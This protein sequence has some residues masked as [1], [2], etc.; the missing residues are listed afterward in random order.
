MDA[1]DALGQVQND[2]NSVLTTVI[3]RKFEPELRQRFEEERKDASVFPTV[4]EIVDFLEDLARQL[5]DSMLGLG[6]ETRKSSKPPNN[7][8]QRPPKAALH[9]SKSPNFKCSLCKSNNHSIYKCY[10]FSDLSAEKRREFIKSAG[11]CFNCLGTSHSVAQCGS[12]VT[13]HTC[14]DRHHTLLHRPSSNDK[15]G[16]STLTT[17]SSG[18]PK[19]AHTCASQHNTTQIVLLGTA[20]VLCRDSSGELQTVRVMIDNGS[21]ISAI[22][23]KCARR[24]GLKIQPF[25]QR[26]SGLSNSSVPNPIGR[27]DCTLI[28]RTQPSSQ[29][30]ASALV[31][32]SI[33]GPQPPLNV[34]ASVIAQVNSL[35]LADP[36]FHKTCEI[37][38]LLGADLYG[39]VMLGEKLQNQSNPHC[40]SSI[41]GWVLIGNAPASDSRYCHL[42]FF[43]F[44][45]TLRPLD[46]ALCKF[47]EIESISQKR[48]PDPAE[49]ACENLFA[50]QHSRTPQGRY[51][52]PLPFSGDPK[53]LGSNRAQALK[54]YLSLERRLK[55]DPPLYEAYQN[56]FS[57]YLSLG[58]M[59]L[60]D[61]P[62][63]YIIPH[64]PVIKESS[65]TTKVRAVF[66]GSARDENQRS[67]NDFLMKGPKLQRDIPDIIFN[68]RLQPIALCCDIK[69]MYR[70]VLV[71]DED[72][73][74][75]HIFWRPHPESEIQEYELLTVTYGLTPSAFL[76]QRS[77]R[78]LST[79]E[80]PDFPLASKSLHDYTYVDDITTGSSDVPC[81]I[82]L[83]DELIGIA[84]KGGFTL[85]K[86][87]SN[88]PEVMADI[89]PDRRATF[90][91]IRD[92]E[93]GFLSVLGSGWIPEID[94]FIYRISTYP[95]DTPVTKR[96]VL[97]YIACAFDPCGWLAPVI[98]WMK[99]F[100]LGMQLLWRRTLDWD[101]LVE[102]NLH[103][104]WM[105]FT[106]EM[107][108][109][110]NF[111]VPRLLISPH[112]K[113]FR[114][115]GF[116]DASLLG[117]GAVFYLVSS[118]S[119]GNFDSNL[120]CAKSKVAPLSPT[121]T[122]PRLELS[123]ALLLAQLL[124][125]LEVH[126]D[127]LSLTEI[128]LFT[129]STT[130]LGW[131]QKSPHLLHT[132]VS[133]RVSRIIEICPSG[134]W[135]HISTDFNPA[136][137]L[138]RGATPSALLDS[139]LWL[140]GPPF[141]RQRFDSW[142]L[143]PATLPEE[144][145]EIKQSYAVTVPQ[146]YNFWIELFSK[147][148]SLS[149]LV[150]TIG[151]IRRFVMLTRKSRSNH[152]HHSSNIL[153]PEERDS[154]RDFCVRI[155]QR[156]HLS[157]EIHTIESQDECPPTFASLSPFIDSLGL[158]RV[159]GRF[160]TC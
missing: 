86:M 135:H 9:A 34:A 45:T 149:K 7:S 78:Q 3:L 143:M 107:H 63:K 35:Q 94:S 79:D 97:S 31:L 30:K 157:K 122:I 123:A 105:Q 130:V 2:D 48:A 62:S 160:E 113:D 23:E 56:F 100:T 153:T 112:S 81:A 72:C 110:E 17:N 88:S 125:S 5:E 90:V 147:F 119:D 104:L 10:K 11:N 50:Q 154:S 102:P 37:D 145:P 36:D 85:H 46:N 14:K 54:Q 73:Q 138:S 114:L 77:V 83:K 87:A 150:G 146:N 159:G 21:Q 4:S 101:Q 38:F 41:F 12:K 108:Q 116:C 111:K 141:L 71:R 65:S 131:L 28:S 33:A 96:S 84:D 118:R 156:F 76:A 82:Q 144:L 39:D 99:H 140:H 75:Q 59:K 51:V 49:I 137:L 67:L 92:F 155:T 69:M 95:S 106:S 93:D 68:F 66:N 117:Y 89:H 53:N 19:S 60:A 29:I 127:S 40:Y 55:K 136:D 129:D 80:K 142:P 27:S 148:S 26:L 74:Y 103:K 1:L 32:K 8:P 61:K 158:L 115:V 152:P 120:I 134:I 91:S 24:L 43:S 128:L 139:P 133:N 42:N 57:E 47:W 16:D 20:L 6:K 44:L 25:Q 58:H 121:L 126:F 22:T 151:Y 70:Q 98:F 132:F 18:P 52:V 109:L 15:Q 64:H 13:C 124:Q